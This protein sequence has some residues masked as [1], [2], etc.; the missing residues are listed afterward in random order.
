[1]DSWSLCTSPGFAEK[2]SFVLPNPHAHQR[3]V[4][5]SA[6][7]GSSCLLFFGICVSPLSPLPVSPPVL[8]FPQT[9]AL[10]LFCH[11]TLLPHA[12]HGGSALHWIYK[13]AL[14]RCCAVQG[15]LCLAG[16]HPPADPPARCWSPGR[17]HRRGRAVAR[18]CPTA[19]WGP[20][21][22]GHWFLRLLLPVVTQRRVLHSLAG[23]AGGLHHL[24]HVCAVAVCPH[25]PEVS[26]Q[27]LWPTHFQTHS[28]PCPQKSPSPQDPSSPPR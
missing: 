22:K 6:G 16:C 8:T 12:C 11:S 1:M 7:S 24:L 13:H 19:S 14:F 5:E 27:S 21:T 10:H 17:M 3:A 28:V 18:T 26:L 23:G 20:D 9:S 2:H 25:P 15:A 4:V